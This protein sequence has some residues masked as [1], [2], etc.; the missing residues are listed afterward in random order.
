MN[1]KYRFSPFSSSLPPHTNITTNRTEEN[2]YNIIKYYYTSSR[3]RDLFFKL[4]KF[5]AILLLLLLLLS[6]V[7]LN[8]LNYLLVHLTR[9][10]YELRCKTLFRDGVY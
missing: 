7:K 8:E 6:R 3:F 5:E 1:I 10:T 9:V 4:P 2:Y